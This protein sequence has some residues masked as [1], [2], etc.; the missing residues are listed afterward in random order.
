MFDFSLTN[1]SPAKGKGAPYLTKTISGGTGTTV[2]MEDARMFCDGYGATVGDSI[3]IGSNTA[4]T[5]VQ[6]VDNTTLV[7]DRSISWRAGDGVTLASIGF[8]SD[9]GAIK[10]SGGVVT[11]T[12]PFIVTQPQS[13]TIPQGNSVTF[14]V[15]ATG[16][17][18]MT[19]QWYKNGTVIAGATASSYTTTVSMTDT[20]S[21]YRC[22]ITN[23]V[24]TTSSTMATLTVTTG[25][26]VSTAI[27]DGGFDAPFSDN[28]S[29][30]SNASD[31]TCLVT[32][33]DAEHPTVAQVSINTVG[34]NMQLNQAGIS[35]TGGK[36]YKLSMDATVDTSALPAGRSILVLLHKDTS[37][38]RN[39]GLYKQYDLT[40][41]WA[42]YSTEFTASE[43]STE[44]RLRLWFPDFA[45]PGDIFMFDNITLTEISGT[46][47][48][49]PPPPLV[50]PTI[51]TQ[52]TNVSVVAGAMATF[53][54]VA[55]GSA[56]LAYQ[57]QKNGTILA[58][59][60]QST[61]TISSS[62]SDNGSVY[63]CVVTNQAGVVT[64]SPAS[65]TVTTIPPPPTT[66]TV[67]ISSTGAGSG[68][69]TVNG[70]SVKLP[71]NVTVPIGTVLVLSATPNVGSI[72]GSWSGGVS[73]TSPTVSITAT[74]NTSAVATFSL[75]TTPDTTGKKYMYVQEYVTSPWTP[76]VGI[77]LGYMGTMS[78][79]TK[80]VLVRY[81]KPTV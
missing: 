76:P 20:N 49:P 38:Y 3:L 37:D 77:I 46:I 6:V 80:Q 18:P 39:Y 10:T 32:V 22:S 53:Q 69:V 15:F 48:P 68:G 54:T 1:T 63:V 30:F 74:T 56:P 40:A 28:W 8:N 4:V 65:L 67:T 5:V 17:T 62:I 27:R 58:G 26:V 81:W 51:L 7:V 11:P 71:Y 34:S 24:G 21:T 52:P 12:A 31:S 75:S 41:K 2:S 50:A 23:S 59:A 9:I 79:S 60:T 42:T 36:V 44:G 43:S 13:Q 19:Y 47:T 55:T 29:W 57:W 64:S 78:T 70:S 61:Y 33:G 72:F 25:T 45:Q 66:V 73:S 35:I 14:S 16:T